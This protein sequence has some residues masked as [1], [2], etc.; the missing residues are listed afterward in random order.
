MVARR[1]D[2]ERTRFV[3]SHEPWEAKRARAPKG[4]SWELRDARESAR[5]LLIVVN[6]RFGEGQPPFEHTERLAAVAEDER[7]T[8]RLRVRAGEALSR[9]R[10]AGMRGAAGLDPAPPGMRKARRRR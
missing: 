9:L 5:L 2:P 3:P 6:A 1:D 7:L 10:V 4:S 8:P